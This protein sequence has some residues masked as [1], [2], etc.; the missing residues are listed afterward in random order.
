[1]PDYSVLSLPGIIISST[2]L[3]ERRQKGEIFALIDVREIAQWQAATLPGAH[4]LNVYDYFIPDSTE[5]GASSLLN[6]FQRAW[7]T[8]NISD[9]VIPIFFEQQVGMRSPRGAWFALC[10]GIQQPLVLDGGLEAWQRAGGALMPGSG[11]CAVVSAENP[12]Y[13]ADDGARIAQLN[14]LTATRAEVLAA[15]VQILDVRRPSEFSG[16][17]AHECCQR[18]GRIPGARLLFWEDVVHNGAFRD[19][20]EIRQL[21]EQAGLQPDQR[22]V[23]YCH[24]GARAA[25]VFIALQLAGYS[26]LAIYVG[27]WHEWAEHAELP[28]LTGFN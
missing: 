4:H 2:E 22:V 20:E 19:A 27:S 13:R 9:N 17:F 23:I 24:R 5:A 14:A 18:A 1:M 10:G 16:E 7:Q 25:T 3:I 12:D 6:A 28:L 15:E 26:Q 8:L 21:A 11:N